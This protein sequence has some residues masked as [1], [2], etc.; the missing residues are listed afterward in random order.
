MLIPTTFLQNN[1]PKIRNTNQQK[2]YYLP[3]IITLWNQVIYTV[4][5]CPSVS[6]L[7]V[8]NF[9]ELYRAEKY[10]NTTHLQAL[11]TQ[12]VRICCPDSINLQGTLHAAPG[13][14]IENNVTIKGNVVI[15]P[16]SIIEANS[17]LNNVTIGANTVVKASSYIVS[18]KSQTM[19]KLG[20]LLISDQTAKCKNT[21][22]LVLL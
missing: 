14:T 16:G 1:I 12:G 21:L 22:R 8:N 11:M 6:A 9:H 5:A 20:H 15:G 7:G 19:Q 18:S 17:Y 4:E 3:D 2:E 13:V 10:Y